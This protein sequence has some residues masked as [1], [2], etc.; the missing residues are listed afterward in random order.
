MSI[1]DKI[2]S[3]HSSIVIR[4]IPLPRMRTFSALFMTAIILTQAFYNVGI[5]A[6]WLVNRAKI[7]ETLCINR[8]KPELHCDGKCYLKK[9]IAASTQQTPSSENNVPMPDLKKG[10]E[11]AEIVFTTHIIQKTDTQEIL[12]EL[13]PVV[14]GFLAITP[15]T[16]IFHPPA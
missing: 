1:I 2:D 9:K 7:A 6:Y 3:C 16:A 4:S 11:L 5:T 13:I 15:E 14:P 12:P 8:D 10:I